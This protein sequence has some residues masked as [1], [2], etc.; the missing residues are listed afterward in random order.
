MDEH[1]IVIE[2]EPEVEALSFEVAAEDVGERL[3]SFLASRME[4]FSRSRVQRLIES[5]DVLVNAETAKSSYRLRDGDRIEVEITQAIDARF[6][7]ENIPIDILFEDDD[8]IVVN[9]PAGMVVHPGSG[10]HSGTLANALAFHFERLAQSGGVTRPGI[11][12]RLDKNTSGLLVVAKTEEAHEKLSDQF[13]SREVFKS[14]VALVHG[15]VLH[16]RGT[17]DQPIA[18]DPRARVRMAVIRGGRAAFS[19]YRVRRRFDR[20]TLLDV[21]I[22]TGRTHQIR[23]HLSWLKHPVVGDALY[24][25]GRD[26]TVTDVRVR[27]AI[28]KLGRVFLHA[29][30]LRFR[31]PSTNHELRFSSPLASELES[32]LIELGK[33]SES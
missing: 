21:E 24:G 9:K 16:D 4:S 23:V 18:R 8:L 15:I 26:K 20:F 17:I 3:D 30:Q 22:K 32:F 7:P 13:R 29:E 14:Y 2:G 11:V 6:S 10:V 31:H 19:S 5:D 33:R 1:E 25:G 27:A 28:T 12:H